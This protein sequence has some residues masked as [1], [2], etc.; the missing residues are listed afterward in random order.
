MVPLWVTV[1][2][3]ISVSV[4]GLNVSAGSNWFADTGVNRFPTFIPFVKAGGSE[5]LSMAITAPIDIA[6]ISISAALQAPWFRTVAEVSAFATSPTSDIGCIPNASNPYF[7]NCAGL[8]FAY[9]NANK[10]PFTASSVRAPTFTGLIKTLNTRARPLDGTGCPSSPPAEDKG[11]TGGV[12]AGSKDRKSK[13]PGHTPNPWNGSGNNDAWNLWQ[14]GYAAGWVQAGLPSVP[15]PTLAALNVRA[16]AACP[17][18]P[19]PP[20]P[21]PLVPTGG[22]GS[23]SGGSIDPNDKVGPAGDASSNHYIQAGLPMTYQ[24]EFENLPTASLA[25]A[26]V[27]ITDQFDPTKFDLSTFTIGSISFGTQVVNVPAGLSSYATIVRIN[28][29]LSVRIQGSLNTT[30]GIAKWTFTTLDPATGLPPSDPTLGFL[31]PDTDGIVGQGQVT[32]SILQKAGLVDGAAITN[33]A[34]I[35]FDANPAIVTPIWTNVIDTIPLTGKVQSLVPKVGTTSFDVNWS[36]TGAGSAAK[37]YAV[38]VSDNGAA[39]TPWL[40]QISTTTATYAGTSGRRYGFYVIVTDG[41]GNTESLKNAAEASI[42]VNGNLVENT[43]SG[44]GGGCAVASRSNSFDAALL[45]LVGLA[46][47]MR[48]RSRR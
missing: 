4:D 36:A 22:S 18:D 19:L 44:G 33:Q 47:V 31:P 39:F 41:A 34:S 6:N 1:P 32:F 10:V 21:P 2:N 38:Y 48:R 9:L 27:V 43:S 26:Q 13:P 3:T 42:A 25:A 8:Y 16:L 24:V 30:T 20:P 15:G 29:T 46:L 11:F 12:T 45:A 40:T 14:A 37:T 17:P 5:T 7:I 23:G 28:A 35:V